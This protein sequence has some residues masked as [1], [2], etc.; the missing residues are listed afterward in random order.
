MAYGTTRRIIALDN[1]LVCLKPEVDILRLPYVP[2]VKEAAV[3]EFNTIQKGVD[4]C[5]FL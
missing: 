5:I 3:R 2:P 1:I 4:A